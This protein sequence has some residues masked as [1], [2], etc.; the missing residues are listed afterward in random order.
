MGGECWD[1]GGGGGDVECERVGGGGVRG[2]RTTRT[3]VLSGE[4]G[5]DGV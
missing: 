4:E 1:G 5:V 3:R 2:V